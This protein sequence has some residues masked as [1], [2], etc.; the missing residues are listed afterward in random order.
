MTSTDN[1]ADTSLSYTFARHKTVELGLQLNE[2][3]KRLGNLK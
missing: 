2:K 3:R 1:N